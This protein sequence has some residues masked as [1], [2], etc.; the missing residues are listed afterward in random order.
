MKVTEKIRMMR[1]MNDWTQEDMAEKL[2]MS[3]NS[4]AKLE[5]GES[6]LYLEKLEKISEV[7]GVDLPDLLSL[8]KQGLIWL[9]NGDSS[10]HSINYYGASEQTTVEIEKMKLT[11][12]HKN[13]LLSQKDR[14]LKR[15]EQQIDR[16]NE[17]I[18]SLQEKL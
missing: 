10:S 14:M 2:H 6:K 4:Y 13:E 5:R 11:I 12:Q 7:F 15:Q 16:L 9:I 17:I 8:N 3:L 1:A 18:K